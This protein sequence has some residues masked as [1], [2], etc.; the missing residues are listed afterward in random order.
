MEE[1]FNDMLTNLELSDEHDRATRKIEEDEMKRV[2]NEVCEKSERDNGAGSN[3]G[4]K[5][6]TNSR[7]LC[8]NA[9]GMPEPKYMSHS[10]YVWRCC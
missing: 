10:D 2:Q 4:H 5:I 8:R 1:E 3:M 6:S 9:A 7:G